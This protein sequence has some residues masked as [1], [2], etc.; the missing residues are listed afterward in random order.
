MIIARKKQFLIPFTIALVAILFIGGFF[1]L[2]QRAT[3]AAVTGWKAGNIMDDAVMA[4][5]GTM[6]VK[7]IQSFLNSKV[8]TCDTYGK[9]V[10]EFSGG[11][12]YN[13][14]GKITR[15]EWGRYKYGQTKFICLKN[16]TEGGK[17]AAQIIYNVAQKYT[18]NPQVLIVLL[19]KEQ[20]L[21]TDTWPLNSQYRSATGYG[22]P[23]TA[24]CD[25][26]YYGLTNQLEWAAKMFRAIL[27]NSPSWYTPF[28]LGN[29]YIQYNPTASCGGSNVYIENRATQALYSYT[30]YQPNKA[31]L[32][33]GWGTAPCGAY[34]N[35]NFKLYFNEWFGAST[36]PGATAILNRYN[37]MDT[38]SKSSLGTAASEA[39]CNL[40]NGGCY[41]KY[42]QGA[43][44]WSNDTGAWESYGSIRDR[45]ANLGY[46]DGELGYPTGAPNCTIKDNGCY[47]RYEGGYIIGKASTGYWE[48][49]GGIR[50]YWGSVGYQESNLGY[51]V[52]GEK[53]LADGGYYQKYE[54]GYVIG[55]KATGYW[56]SSGATR[57]RW[58][59]LGYQD[60]ELGY[61][62]GTIRCG[63]TDGGC[64]QKYENG[65]I[66]G[67]A[68]TGYWESKGGIRTSW[69]AFGYQEGTLGYP[70]GG[71]KRLTSGG[72]YQKYEGGY[73]IGKKTTGYWES[74]GA[75]R[76][77][78]ASMGYQE[79]ELGYPIG[80]IKTTG[81]TLSQ[82]YEHKKIYH[83]PPSTTWV[84][85]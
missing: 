31:T 17:S 9:Q 85:P 54:N 3:E 50:A 26:D 27:N 71:E 28:E 80:S 46:Q 40:R 22:C 29:N 69:T 45:W 2:K 16:A 42:T 84:T 49:K 44:I 5:K 24:P 64:Y 37:S 60:G 81:S 1:A 55:K 62:V 13:G 38:A 39:I 7:K 14:D 21:V 73:I 61:P 6:S 82:P 77:R 66:I 15:A 33:A 4:D 56:E 63:I 19:Q 43:I 67:K 72:Y 41:Q 34:G 32:K 68:S 35:R 65:Y 18:I 78:W 59:N 30:P 8:S 36:N 83:Q 25:S 70:I 12:D 53:K 11:K 74:Y 23:D 76:D 10:S 58:M 75:I 79:G 57:D 20:S 52:G 51:P 47:Q 48:S